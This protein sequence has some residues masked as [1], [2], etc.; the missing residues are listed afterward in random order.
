M[1]RPP[2]GDAFDILELF[3]N[4]PYPRCPM[5]MPVARCAAFETPKIGSD[6][7]PPPSGAELSQEVLE[8]SDVL[9]GAGPSHDQALS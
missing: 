4:A 9:T 7:T 6:V 8:V 5:P 2:A 1:A 3:T